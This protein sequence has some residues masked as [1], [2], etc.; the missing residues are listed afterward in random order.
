MPTKPQYLVAQLLSQ[1]TNE[2]G[3]TVQRT[4]DESVDIIETTLDEAGNLVDED[5][6]GNVADLPE[7]HPWWQR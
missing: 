3:Q 7:E 2:A 1:R 6:V 4:V 5:I